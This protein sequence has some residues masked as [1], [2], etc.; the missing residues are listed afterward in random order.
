VYSG[1]GVGWL[2]DGG[3]IVVPPG[4]SSCCLVL[5]RLYLIM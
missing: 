1:V 4:R 3:T 5:A 2:A